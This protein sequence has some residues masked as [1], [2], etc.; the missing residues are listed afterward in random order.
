MFGIMTKSKY[1]TVLAIFVAFYFCQVGKIYSIDLPENNKKINLKK[2]FSE[3]VI[4]NKENFVYKISNSDGKLLM[5]AVYSNDIS[6][7]I[8]GYGGRVPVLVFISPN[9]KIFKLEILNNNETPE[10]IEHLEANNFFLQYFGKSIFDDFIMSKDIDGY[11]GATISAKAINNEVKNSIDYYLKKSANKNIN[12]LDY[13]EYFGVLIG[14][15][16][17]MIASFKRSK[18]LNFL[19]SLYSIIIFGYILKIFFSIND[20]FRIFSK[21]F[22]NNFFS[23]LFIIY[24]FVFIFLI[25]NR[26]IYCRYLCPFGNLSSL[27]FKIARYFKIPQYSFRIPDFKF[28]ILAAY[29]AFII[30]GG[31]NYKLEPYGYIFSNIYTSVYFYI[32]FII[33]IFSAINNRFYCK[34][35]CPISALFF[36]ILKIKSAILKKF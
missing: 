21:A 5:T 12:S 17:A 1:L 8:F 10:Y 15:F 7:D 29:I 23:P 30:F 28:M 35:F 36:T 14:L 3:N 18:I 19:C 9:N 26:N 34:Y 31:K 25:F 16:I 11:T 13:P 2:F 32:A 33:L 6:A 24:I 20:I 22:E 4:I 27:L